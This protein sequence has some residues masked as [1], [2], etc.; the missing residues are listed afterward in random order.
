M[1]ISTT[2]WLF[3]N[4]AKYAVIFLRE[5]T[6]LKVEKLTAMW[7]VMRNSG[8]KFSI[9]TA[10]AKLYLHIFTDGRLCVNVEIT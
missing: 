7:N 5:N 3:M 10:F 8:P 1:V 9:F 4:L 6:N 2:I